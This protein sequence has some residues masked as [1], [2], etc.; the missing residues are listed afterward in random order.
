MNIGWVGCG[1][2]GTGMISR[3]IAS[4]HLV[5]IYN[6][7]PDKTKP[8]VAKGAL[9]AHSAREAAMGAD[10]IFTT[11]TDDEASYAVWEGKEGIVSGL[12]DHAIALDC[13]TLSLTRCDTLYKYITKHSSAHFLT[14]PLI[15]SYQDAEDA[16]LIFLVGGDLNILPQI[17]DLLMLMGK[18]VTHVGSHIQAMAFKL[19]LTAS[20]SIQI[21]L[22]TEL[23]NFLKTHELNSSMMNL[24]NNL[25]FTKGTM[26]I[27]D[28]LSSTNQ[29]DQLFPIDLIHKDLSNLILSQQ[30]THLSPKLTAAARDIFA[31]AT[32]EE[33]C[34]IF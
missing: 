1:Q 34:L 4:G 29:F 31:K 2:M 25:P 3:L 11:V 21:M 20:T 8:L 32:I 33:K 23:L 16:S 17:N 19:A 6:R 13:S 9:Q 5:T 7:T 27:I 24:F 28:T 14:A 22:Q 12:Q 30:S 18:N 10:I 26:D 15:G